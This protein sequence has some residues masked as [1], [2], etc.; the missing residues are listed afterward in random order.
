MFDDPAVFSGGFVTKTS[1]GC[2]RGGGGG[3]GGGGTESVGAARRSELRGCGRPDL[4]RYFERLLA[5]W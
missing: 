3:G 2:G 5:I 4:L 1:G